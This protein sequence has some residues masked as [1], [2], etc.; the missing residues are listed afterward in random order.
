MLSIIAVSRPCARREDTS[1]E[2]I[3][4]IER[5]LI[6]DFRALDFAV[7]NV[8]E[9]KIYVA[10]RSIFPFERFVAKPDAPRGRTFYV[11]PFYSSGAFM[12]G[13]EGACLE[14]VR[15]G[16]SP[17]AQGLP[18]PWVTPQATSP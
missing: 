10:R 13:L 4:E 17:T 11:Y 1:P 9:Q 14:D 5:Q 8:A 12:Y 18:V 15:I 7:E 3:N 16:P 2:P 6:H